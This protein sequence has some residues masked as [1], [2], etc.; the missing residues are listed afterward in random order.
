M[1]FTEAVTKINP[2]DKIEKKQSKSEQC[3]HCHGSGKCP[4]YKSETEKPCVFCH[5][6]EVCSFC[7][8]SGRK[9]KLEN[10]PFDII[11][12]KMKASQR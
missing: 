7:G 10:E 11:L 9:E 3:A 12:Q 6:K 5:G 8:G 2:I 4:R 1:K